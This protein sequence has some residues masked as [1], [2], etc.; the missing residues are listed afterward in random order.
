MLARVEVTTSHVDEDE[1]VGTVSFRI[2]R[3]SSVRVVFVCLSAC[4]SV[5]L[6]V[7]LSA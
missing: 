3:S 6:I 2:F 1:Y 4:P 7:Y 5:C